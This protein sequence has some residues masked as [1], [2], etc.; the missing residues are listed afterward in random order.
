[1]WV[2]LRSKEFYIYILYSLTSDIYYVGYTNDYVRRLGKHNRSEQTTF[3]S[4]HR[5]WVPRAV[6]S[7]GGQEVD[8]IRIERFMKRQKSRRLIGGEILRWMLL[9]KYTFLMA[10]FIS[11]N[12]S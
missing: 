1:L 2:F 9:L 3:N 7:C 12:L 11:G 4:K 6:F 8:A 10:L 5:P